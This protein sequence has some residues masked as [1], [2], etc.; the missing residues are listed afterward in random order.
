MI[1]HKVA[2]G[3]LKTN[4]YL[5]SDDKTKETA[6]IDPGDEAGKIITEIENNDLK[7]QV[8]L[9][10]HAHFDHIGAVQEVKKYFKIDHLKVGE[11]DEVVLGDTKLEVIETPGHKEDCV[12]FVC[13]DCV[14]S[15]DTLF[16]GGVGRTDLEGSDP[17][18]MKK[19]FA[20][21]MDLPGGFRV[22]PGHG[23]ETTIAAERSHLEP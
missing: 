15:G 6:V 9:L 2:V 10:T 8:I 5:V 4:C 13:G 14:F 20:R 11:G 3:F 17:E 21:L 16:R 1:I 22:Y 18:A 23:R 12:C 19:S 7:P